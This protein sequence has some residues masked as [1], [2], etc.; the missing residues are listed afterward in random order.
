MVCNS[1]WKS[2][3]R[4]GSDKEPWVQL[5]FESHWVLPDEELIHEQLISCFARLF[6]FNDIICKENVPILTENEEIK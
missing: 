4:C 1:C 2:E 3:S 5:G 6:G